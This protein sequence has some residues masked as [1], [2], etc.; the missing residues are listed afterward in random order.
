MALSVLVVDDDPTFRAVAADMLTAAGLHVLGE[1][2]SAATALAAAIDLKP[3]AALVDFDL[4]DGNGITLA[5]EF[6]DLPTRPRV[7]LT[8][9]DGDVVRP[10]HVRRAGAIAFVQKADLSDDGLLELFASG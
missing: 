9:V 7:V 10:E 3:D 8:S 1:A 4:P 2:D 5:C 6:R